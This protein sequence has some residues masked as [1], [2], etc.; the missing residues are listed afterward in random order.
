MRQITLKS[1][2]QEKER[3]LALLR[4]EALPFEDD[5]AFA[6]NQRKERCRNDLLEFARTYMPHYVPEEFSDYHDELAKYCSLKNEPVFFSGPK[7]TGKSVLVTICDTVKAMA[8]KQ[9]MFTIIA[10]ETEDQAGDRASYIQFE[11]E[12]NPRLK[13]DFGDLRGSW[14][15]ESKD[16]VLSNGARCKSRGLGQQVAGLIHRNFR[17][18]GFRVEDMESEQSSRNPK[19][20]KVVLE[21]V[22]DV[23]LGGLGPNFSFIWGGNIISKRCALYKLINEKDDSGHKRHV[24]EIF[25]LLQKDGTSL[26]PGVWPMERI[27]RM[28]RIM[29]P[30][31]FNKVYQND[32]V[33][34]DAKFRPEWI[35]TITMKQ[36][37]KRKNLNCKVYNDPIVEP[38]STS[39][40]AAIVVGGIDLD[41]MDD[42]GGPTMIVVDAK[43]AKLTPSAMMDHHYRFDELWRP[44]EHW[45]EKVGF[46]AWL[47]RDFDRAAQKRYA[48]N[49]RPYDTPRINKEVRIDTLT[50]PIERGKILFCTENGDVNTLI[51]Q[52]I[53]HGNAGVPDD[54][55]DAL[56]S[57]WDV[58]NR[59]SRGMMYIIDDDD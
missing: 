48:L 6:K 4:T 8:Y 7:G 53:Y 3:I 43:I 55:P 36:L 45:F 58:F 50:S 14:L 17:P 19:R 18:D 54:G 2:D 44:G 31:S 30:V 57:L 22:I 26:C 35:R 11:F 49:V 38:T 9:R 15:W 27:E 28:R 46:S 29:G 20:V 1:F 47:Q 34:P 23:A 21:W 25:Q 13:Q 16:F 51:E 32:P 56:S 33:D 40:T 39:D 52:L 12:F 41:T 42:E 24:G 37:K 59:G 10:S 5:S